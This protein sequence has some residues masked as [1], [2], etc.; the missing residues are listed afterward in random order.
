M[1]KIEIET[2]ISFNDEEGFTQIST[3][4]KRIKSRMAKL[5]VK[6]HHKQGDY[7]CYRV[8][9]RWIKISS[10]RK[11]TEIQRETARRN[12]LKSPI[13]SKSVV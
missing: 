3:R 7:E 9:K 2:V 6:P 11:V 4:Q 12:L 1:K 10:P 13:L 8:P 5:G